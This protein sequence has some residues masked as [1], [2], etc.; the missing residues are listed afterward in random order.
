MT[1]PDEHDRRLATMTIAAVYPLYVRKIERKGRTVAELHQVIQWLT[2]FDPLALQ[3]QIARDA[4]EA[5]A[6]LARRK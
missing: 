5:R 3:A 1:D 4:T 6:A 2:G